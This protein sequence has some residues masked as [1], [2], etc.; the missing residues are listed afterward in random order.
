MNESKD[1]KA[2][3]KNEE[4]TPLGRVLVR[5]PV[6]PHVGKMIV[7]A[8]LLGVGDPMCSI[9]ALI[10]FPEPFETPK[11][12]KFLQV[13]HKRMAGNRCSDH[14]ALITAYQGWLSAK[15]VT[16]L[17]IASVVMN[18]ANVCYVLLCV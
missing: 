15:L 5:L 16:I 17:N 18:S 14:V 3:D 4:L 9:A 2:L 13:V 10:S 8:T 7:L 1:M 12:F 6:E 11:E